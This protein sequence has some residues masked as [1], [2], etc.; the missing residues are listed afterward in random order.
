M[1]KVLGKI[2]YDEHKWFIC[3]DL[4]ITTIL[5]GQ[6]LGYTKVRVIFVCGIVGLGKNIGIKKV[7]LCVSLSSQDHSMFFV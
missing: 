6:Q 2:K 7:G 5:L 3:G 1:K 4:K